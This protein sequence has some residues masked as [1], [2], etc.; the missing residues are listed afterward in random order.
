MMDASAEDS[1]G[2]GTL[3]IGELIV[4]RMVPSQSGGGMLAGSECK[5]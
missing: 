5:V 2:S 3:V 1:D 4:E